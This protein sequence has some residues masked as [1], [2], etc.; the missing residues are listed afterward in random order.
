MCEGGGCIHE[1]DAMEDALAIAYELRKAG[2]R[3]ELW[4]KP[5]KPGK[6]RKSTDERAIG[7]AVIVQPGANEAINLWSRKDPEKTNEMVRGNPAVYRPDRQV[8][9]LPRRNAGSPR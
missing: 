3:A 7:F 1:A 8:R 6:V 4:S 5:E 2:I 9:P